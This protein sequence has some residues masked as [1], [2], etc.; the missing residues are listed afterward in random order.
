MRRTH[1]TVP[2][3]GQTP[4]SID[5]S[6]GASSL[7]VVS[8][9]GEQSDAAAGPLCDS[10]GGARSAHAGSNASASNARDT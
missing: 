2:Y 1:T 6:G 4:Y 3:G 8:A 7:H 10:S 9:A 5:I